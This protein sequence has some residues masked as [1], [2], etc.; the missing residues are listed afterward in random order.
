MTVVTVC[1]KWSRAVGTLGIMYPIKGFN[2]WAD[3]SSLDSGLLQ[4][5]Y[6]QL[7]QSLQGLP[8]LAAIRYFDRSC[9]RSLVPSIS[10]FHQRINNWAHSHQMPSSNYHHHRTTAYTHQ[11]P[12]PH[13]PPPV[14][15]RFPGTSKWPRLDKFISSGC[16]GRQMLDIRAV[17]ARRDLIIETTSRASSA[18][19]TSTTGGFTQKKVSQAT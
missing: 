11:P 2:Q 6:K 18:E 19:I 5:I 14:T 17:A 10:S 3:M 15:R 12:P 16:P 8:H 1:T 7:D 4:H 9:H 13:Q